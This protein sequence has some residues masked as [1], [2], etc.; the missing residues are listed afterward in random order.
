MRRMPR[1]TPVAAETTKMSVSPATN[2][3][4]PVPPAST[5]HWKPMPARNCS[6]TSA[7]EVAMP[8]MVANTASVSTSRPSGESMPSAPRNGVRMAAT[9]S[10]AP[11]WKTKYAIGTPSAA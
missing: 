4:G 2:N 6:L 11:R 3:T 8:P 7:T 5:P 1:W 10:G 9:R